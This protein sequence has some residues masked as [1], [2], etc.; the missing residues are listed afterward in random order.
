M[1]MDRVYFTYPNILYHQYILVSFY[2]T[3]VEMLR[4]ILLCALNEPAVIVK[5]LLVATVRRLGFNFLVT[6]LA[7]GTFKLI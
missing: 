6:C 3:P 2:G 7:T 1:T 5:E 4:I